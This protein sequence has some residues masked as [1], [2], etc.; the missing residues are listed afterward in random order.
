MNDI[1]EQIKLL[2]ISKQ[3]V[4]LEHLNFG[5]CTASINAFKSKLGLEL[6]ETFYSF[7]ELFNGNVSSQATIWDSMT[8]LPLSEII[9]EKK[10]R[11]RHNN[12]GKF[13][14]WKTGSWWDP[15]WVPFLSDKANSLICIDTAGSYGGVKYQIIQWRNDN[16]SRIILFESFD[17]WLIALFQLIDN[18][19]SNI[20]LQRDV[21]SSYCNN[22]IDK[23]VTSLNKAYPKY[24]NAT[25]I[26]SSEN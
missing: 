23:I 20:A 21:Y 6:P 10:L 16:P 1:V 2:I 9:E 18:F 13:A 14:S 19:D 3:D 15:H 24:V 8:L 5:A 12:L 25:R 7:Y 4:L 22:Q 26:R 17:Y 11:D